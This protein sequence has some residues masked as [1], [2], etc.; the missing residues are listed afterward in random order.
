MYKIYSFFIFLTETQKTSVVTFCLFPSMN[1]VS[2][3]S[4]PGMIK[5]SIELHI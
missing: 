3:E 2:S 4:S 1:F 5:A